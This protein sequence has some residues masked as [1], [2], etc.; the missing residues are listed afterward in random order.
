[1]QGRVRLAAR[2]SFRELGSR[3]E[4]FGGGKERECGRSR[5]EDARKL[6]SIVGDGKLTER[7]NLQRE[8]RKSSEQRLMGSRGIRWK[9]EFRRVPGSRGM[10]YGIPPGVTD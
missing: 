3:V 9:G 8:A 10:T 2:M 7:R 5:R 1:M 4:G 6:D